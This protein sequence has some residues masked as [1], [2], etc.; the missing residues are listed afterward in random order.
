MYEARGKQCSVVYQYLVANLTHLSGPGFGTG[1]NASVLNSLVKRQGI[2]TVFPVVASMSRNS[3]GICLRSWLLAVSM[4][5]NHQGTS[6]FLFVVLRVR[7]F[8]QHDH[9]QYSPIKLFLLQQR[10]ITFN[11]WRRQLTSRVSPRVTTVMERISSWS[12]LVLLCV[13]PTCSPRCKIVITVQL[14]WC[15]V[16][17]SVGLYVPWNSCGVF[18]TGPLVCRTVVTLMIVLS[19]LEAVHA[20]VSRTQACSRRQ[21]Y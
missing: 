2:P 10:C 9:D 15:Q 8:T 21:P 7:H 17:F 16:Y 4:V 12:Y 20:Y 5:G 14:P 1:T 11:L 6:C 19:E 3:A 18:D 13:S